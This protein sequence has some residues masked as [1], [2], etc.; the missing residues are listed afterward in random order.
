MIKPYSQQTY[1]A[2][3]DLLRAGQTPSWRRVREITGTGSSNDLLREIRQIV[4]EVAERA[5][6]GDYPKQAQDAFWSLWM[7]LKGIASSELDALREQLFEQ[8]RLA[9]QAATDAQIDAA[10]AKQQL[11]ERERQVQLLENQLSLAGARELKLNDN[12]EELNGR[13]V[14]EQEKLAALHQAHQSAIEAKDQDIRTWQ[15]KLETETQLRHQVLAETVTEHQAKVSR[16]EQEIKNEL[17]RYDKDTAKLMRQLDADR[18]EHRREQLVVNGELKLAREQLA[19]SRQ[20][21]AAVAGENSA[22]LRQIGDLT[23]QRQALEQR[24]Q[25]LQDETRALSSQVA[26]L[27]GTLRSLEKLNLDADRKTE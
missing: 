3:M 23:N 16:L 15:G 4:I 13:I 10:Q 25:A 9:Q 6:A 14:Q 12:I 1:A 20:Q 22:L 7:E 5:A 2:V 19:D 17:D 11:A 27:T 26:E 24:N 21:S 8:N 18:T